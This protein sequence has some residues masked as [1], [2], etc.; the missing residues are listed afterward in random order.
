[1]ATQSKWLQAGINVSDK[2]E[3]VNYY[4]RNFS[5][6]LLEITHACGYE[7]PCQFSMDDINIS[8]GDN[9]Q[10]T[11]LASTYGYHKV[12]VEFSGCKELE[13]CEYLGGTYHKDVV[14]VSKVRY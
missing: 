1:M 9:N 13:K 4:F 12:S 10:T 6:E 3:R 11:S 5:K 8:K 7:H 14:D 2:A